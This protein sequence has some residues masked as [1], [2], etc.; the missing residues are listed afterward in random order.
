MIFGT[1]KRDRDEIIS[2]Q[3]KAVNDIKIG[4]RFLI[5]QRCY[6]VTEKYP[7]F[8]RLENFGDKKTLNKGDLITILCGGF[9]Y[10]ESE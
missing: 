7:N 6:R 10:E 8:V 4:Q 5:G 2:K 9:D 1:D 3:R